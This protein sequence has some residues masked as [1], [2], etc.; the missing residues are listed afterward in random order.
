MTPGQSFALACGLAVAGAKLWIINSYA[1]PFPFGDQWIEARDLYQPYLG[2]VLNVR[3]WLG[4]HNEHRIFFSRVVAF[5]LFMIS[6]RWD[7]V[8]QMLFNAALHATTLGLIVFAL[9]AGFSTVSTAALAVVATFLCAV[10]FAWENTLWGFQTQFYCVVLFGFVCAYLAHDAAAFSPRWLVSLL[11]GGLS[12]LVMASGALTLL[13]VAAVIALQLLGGARRGVREW[14]GVLLQVAISFALVFDAARRAAGQVAS[15]AVIKD[16]AVMMGW[17]ATSAPIGA[18]FAVIAAIVVQSPAIV[19]L[20]RL[21]LE[22]APAGDRRWLYPMIAVWSTS[23]MAAISFGRSG[24]ELLGSRYLDLF[25]IGVLANAACLFSLAERTRRG[26]LA[27]AFWLAVIGLGAGKAAMTLGSDLANRSTMIAAQA[28]NLR[29]Y[30]TTGD[31]ERLR[32][33]QTYAVPF[34]TPEPIAQILGD[35][36]VRRILPELLLG[37]PDSRALRLTKKNMLEAGPVVLSIGIVL[38][39]VALL[40]SGLPERTQRRS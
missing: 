6:G 29:A 3:D 27:A 12:Y 40:A 28:N 5:A 19:M 14:L 32:N 34:S 21:L 1:S 35:Q 39:I 30:L 20:A 17:P 13:A 23:Q 18:D 16:M 38:F 25:A 7:P 8:V 4:F 37:P 31:P 22:R 26:T 24:A 11:I 2:G 10:P 9:S 33:A 15:V 36:N